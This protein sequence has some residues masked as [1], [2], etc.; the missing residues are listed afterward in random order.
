MNADKV[1][2]IGFDLDQ[3]L[4]PKSPE[5][6]E[7]IQ[8]YIYKKIAEHKK[9]SLE[10]GKQLF[11]SHYP[12]ISGRKTLI[13]LG[14]PDAENIIQEAVETADIAPFLVPD[15]KVYDL[16]V[17]LKQKFGSLS[18]IT[19]SSDEVCARKLRALDL[20]A[21]L[22]DCVLAGTFSKSD[23]TAFKMWMEMFRS[24]DPSLQPE[25]FLYV[26]DRAST[27]AIIPISLGMQTVLVNIKEKDK[28]II[29]EQLPT[30][31]DIEPFFER[32]L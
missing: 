29:V 27:D 11:L 24:K 17:R 25:N 19:G 21:N 13:L 1:K 8:N 18:L 5:I 6:D 14:I 4:Y 7:A 23:G 12:G 16:L 2:V 30:L 32:N 28:E 22:F 26:G 3:T 10:E 31:F 15:K 20:P 9:C